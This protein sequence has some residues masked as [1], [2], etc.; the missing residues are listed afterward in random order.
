MLH[1][2]DVN[3]ARPTICVRAQKPYLSLWNT[4]GTEQ[5]LTLVTVNPF[6]CRLECPFRDGGFLRLSFCIK[7]PK[8]WAQVPSQ[9][10]LHRFPMFQVRSEE[11]RVGKEC[12]STCRSR[13]SP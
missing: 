9:Q 3:N 4:G 12:V 5:R 6:T 13:W 8:S 11:R 10:V 2:A 1:T 7:F